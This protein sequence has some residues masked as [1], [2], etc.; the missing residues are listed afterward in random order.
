SSRVRR[1]E[2]QSP[3]SSPRTSPDPSLDE[4][5]R[6]GIYNN[7]TFTTLDNGN[8]ATAEEEDD[9]TELRLF[10]A[11]SA[12]PQTHKIRISSPGAET[13]DAGFIVNRPR[14]YYF[15]EKPDSEQEAE[16][17]AAAVDGET[18]KELAKAPW[19]G[20][21][22]PWKVTTISAAGLQKAVLVGH[23]PSLVTVTEATSKKKRKGKKTRIAIRKK[24]QAVKARQD[25]RNK[26]AKEKED[27]EREKRTR[28][29]REKKLKKKAKDKAKKEAVGGEAAQ[30]DAA[31]ASDSASE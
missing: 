6:T 27:H 7:L 23:P 8:E 21:V 5:F 3:A 1:D 19:P 15:A 24:A 14:S 4:L 2:L 18:V 16:L 10:A 25:E 11:P 26:S 13:D 29:N 30:Q 17:W 28:R 20:A 31:M 12:R 9:E 22:L